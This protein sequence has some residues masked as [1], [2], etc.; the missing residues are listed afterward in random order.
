MVPTNEFIQRKHDSGGK[1]FV[2]SEMIKHLL[3]FQA[4]SQSPFVGSS[5]R[6]WQRAKTYHRYRCKPHWQFL[7][8]W[9]GKKG[10]HDRKRI[11]TL[12]KMF[13]DPITQSRGIYAAKAQLRH[14]TVDMTVKHHADPQQQAP[15][16]VAHLLSDQ[17]FALT[18][19]EQATV[20]EL[21]ERL[22]ELSPAAR[23]SVLQ[24]VQPLAVAA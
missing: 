10:I 1:V 20:A 24:S 22:R 16:E 4:G 5:P 12:R 3:S 13:G 8:D 23:Q 14:K 18:T 9:L 11:H 19:S 15:I 17:P 7:N 2:E 6:E 21:I